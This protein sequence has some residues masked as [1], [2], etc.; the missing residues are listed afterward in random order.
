MQVPLAILLIPLSIRQQH[1]ATLLTI[2]HPFYLLLLKYSM[3]LSSDFPDEVC[4]FFLYDTMLL[5]SISDI[6]S[7]TVMKFFC[8]LVFRKLYAL[9]SIK[10]F[11]SFLFDILF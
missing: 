3:N 10:I 2:M 1:Q 5:L 4:L 7:E 9:L 6:N 8:A 11:T